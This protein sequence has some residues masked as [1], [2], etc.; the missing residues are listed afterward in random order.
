M[1]G[2]RPSMAGGL[3]SM[4]GLGPGGL[5]SRRPSYMVGHG[6]GLASGPSRQS[7]IMSMVRGLVVFVGIV[8]NN[9][10]VQRNSRYKQRTELL[11][12][13]S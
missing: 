12:I 13:S 2:A 6:D 1:S 8:R 3:S 4:S 11:P 10:T 7:S 9:A 5:L